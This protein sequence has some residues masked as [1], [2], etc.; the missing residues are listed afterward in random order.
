MIDPFIT[1]L[2]E[3]QKIVFA[4]S[5]GSTSRPKLLMSF[6]CFMNSVGT[7]S[8]SISVSVNQGKM[9]AVCISLATK[10]WQVERIIP[11]TA[12]FEVT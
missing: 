12:C 1:G 3:A 5:S 7:C 11:I 10:S 6:I 2:C 8:L 4:I 9:Q